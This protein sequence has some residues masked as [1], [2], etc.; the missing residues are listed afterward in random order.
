[1]RELLELQPAFPKLTFAPV[2]ARSTAMV[3]L[4]AVRYKLS[5]Y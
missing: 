5:C 1:M 3:L 4:D 2:L